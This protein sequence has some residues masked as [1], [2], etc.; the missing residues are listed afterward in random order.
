[1]RSTPAGIGAVSAFVP[2]A[3]VDQLRWLPLP[4]AI[5]T[6]SYPRDADVLRAFGA[7][8]Q[9]STVIALVRHAL[10]GERAGWSGPD[11]AR[12]LDA[13]GR[14]QARRLAPLLA[15]TEPGRLVSA[16]TARC[17]QTLEPLAELIDSTIEVDPAFDEP[18]G[19]GVPTRWDPAEPAATA[20]I[21]LASTGIGAVAC[22]QGRMIPA[23]LARL[24][25]GDAAGFHTAKGGGWLL[26]F[27]GTRLAAATA[28]P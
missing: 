12:P 5:D 19:D 4:Q 23:A 8:P 26:A 10:A 28:L 9:V 3:E 13:A 1:M 27:A 25:N 21:R 18:T 15:L 2:N 24:A 7:L 22:G 11:A 14:E 17:V 16:P 6:V 20:L